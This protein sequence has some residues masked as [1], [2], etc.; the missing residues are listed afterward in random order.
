M[1]SRAAVGSPRA[2]LLDLKILLVCMGH[3][4]A[5]RRARRVRLRYFNPSSEDRP[6]RY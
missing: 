3:M 5:L 6:E 4:I 1:A 2:A